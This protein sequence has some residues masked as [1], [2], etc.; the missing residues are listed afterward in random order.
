MV[1]EPAPGEIYFTGDFQAGGVCRRPLLSD[2]E[3]WR[4][5][6]AAAPGAVGFVASVLMPAAR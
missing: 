6:G 3:G 2:E 4:L 1:P 5:P